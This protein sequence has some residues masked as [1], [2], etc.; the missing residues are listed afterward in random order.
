MIRSFRAEVRRQAPSQQVN[1]KLLRKFI[2]KPQ[3]F[4]GD[5]T[6]QI[7]L[8]VVSANPAML[9]LSEADSKPYNYAKL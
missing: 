5:E 9:Q 6:K 7:L 4:R 3:V 2:N 8:P 1:D